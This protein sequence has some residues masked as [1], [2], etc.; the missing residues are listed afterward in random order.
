ML[1]EDEDEAVGFDRFVLRIEFFAC[2]KFFEDVV[3]LC[4]GQAG[5][6]RLDLF[7]QFVEFFGCFADFGPEGFRRVRE[8]EGIEAFGLKITRPVFKRAEL[9][10]GASPSPAH[11]GRP[12]ENVC[13]PRRPPAQKDRSP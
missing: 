4:E 6:L 5:V 1:L 2:A 8:G 11:A 10:V 12:P 13:E 7:A 9:R 3:E